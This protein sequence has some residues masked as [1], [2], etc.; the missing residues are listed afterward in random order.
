MVTPRQEHTATLL[1]TGKVLVAGGRSITGTAALSTAELYD[2]TT[3]TWT[4]TG[5]M[6]GARRL[7]SA[8]QLNTSSNSTTSGKVLVAGG[9]DG[10][11]TLMTAQLYAP[12][13]GTWIAA[14]NL[15]T[16]RYA[17]T[18]TKLVDGKVLFVGG[19]NGSTTLA[20]AAIYN[21]ASGAGSFAATTGPI[22]PQGL[23]A[24]TATLLATSNQQLNSKVLLVGGNNGTSSIAAVYLFDPA[25]SA[26]STLASIPTPREGHTATAACPTASCW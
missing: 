6:T 17:H 21:P 5:S 16:G 20:N 19:V 26:F 18:A 8:T 4:S 2:P 7:H 12:T 24:H 11:S 14:G 23:K 10:T 1:A 15:N 22:P 3:G 13:A 25:Q 9:I